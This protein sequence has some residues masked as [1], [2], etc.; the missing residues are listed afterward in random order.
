MMQECMPP[1][2]GGGINVTVSIDLGSLMGCPPC[3]PPCPPST[4]L[5]NMP[6]DPERD[7][8]AEG[9][10]TICFDGESSKGSFEKARDN[11]AGRFGGKPD[12]KKPDKESNSFSDESEDENKKKD[13][14][15]YKK[16]TKEERP[17]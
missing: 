10:K 13:T 7:L 5:R 2:P 17:Q 6:C 12:D 4:S 3:P 11:V 1:M 9:Y 14:E 16:D 15:K 8:E